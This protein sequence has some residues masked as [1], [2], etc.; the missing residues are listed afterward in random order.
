L[1]RHT[2][3][4]VLIAAVS[5][6]ALAR[7]ATDAGYTPIVADFFADRDTE[8]LAQRV[9]K[10]P[11]DTA[12]GFQWT[13]LE[14]ALETLATNAP[15]PLLGLIYGSGFEDRPQLLGQIA[16]R[17]PLLGN[18]ASTVARINDPARLFPALER[19]AVAHPQTRLELPPEPDGWVAKRLGGA[20]GSHI[21]PAAART[22]RA[23][24]YYQELVSGRSISALFAASGGETIVLG[25]SEQWTA[26]A[27]GKPW[28]YGGA[29][30]PADV[31]RAAA[32]RITGIVSSVAADF[33]L[34]GLNAADFVL[35]GDDPLL[36]EFNPRPGATLDIFASTSTPLLAIHLDAV[37][38][39]A[40]PSYVPV[41]DDATAS[42]IVFAPETLTIPTEMVWPSWAAD[43]PK[44]GQRIDKERPICTLLARAGSAADA[45]RLVQTRVGDMLTALEMFEQSAHAAKSHA[46][47]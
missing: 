9:C 46:H 18:D 39:G 34:T 3:G 32:D 14:P 42:A 30:Q 12:R 38:H 31:S 47:E 25:F 4:S 6:R 11:G 2:R 20:G 26:P 27:P 37:R 33:Q 40:L 19:L 5:G 28:R 7:A 43:L 17:W 1:A 16:E 35:Q 45:R 8:T 24:L 10:V 41:Y 36:L 44:I 22:D 15:S 29:S 13:A 23:D 21:R